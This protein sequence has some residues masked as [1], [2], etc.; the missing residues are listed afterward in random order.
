MVDM[1]DNRLEFAKTVGATHTVNSGKEDAI[2]KILEITDGRGV[3]YAIE[4]VGVEPTW[5]IC[6]HV[7]KEG[8]HIANVGVH[9]KAVNFEL[10]KLWIK[11]PDHY[12][13]SGQCQYHWHAAQGLLFRQNITRKTGHASL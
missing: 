5:N 3:D 6:Q 12:Y 8:G 1:D 2:Q 9:G 10:N 11:N 4:V 7:I 13:R